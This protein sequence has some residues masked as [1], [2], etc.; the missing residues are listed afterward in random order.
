MENFDEELMQEI[1][2]YVRDIND[3]FDPDGPMPEVPYSQEQLAQYDQWCQ[4]LV[5]TKVFG[6]KGHN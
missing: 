1:D 6:S 2:K 4:Q 3:N 5:L